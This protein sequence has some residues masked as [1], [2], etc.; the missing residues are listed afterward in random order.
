MESIAKLVAPLATYTIHSHSQ[1]QWSMEL[2]RN[3]CMG[4][5]QPTAPHFLLSDSPL[6]PSEGPLGLA[7]SKLPIH[8]KGK[9]TS[10][11]TPLL[12]ELHGADLH[13]Q[14]LLLR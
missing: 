11:A 6:S 3:C 12:E 9:E 2:H 5:H 4:E 7:S 1:L 10:M 8:A 14:A 13:L